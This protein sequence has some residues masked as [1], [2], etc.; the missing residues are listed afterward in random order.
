VWRTPALHRDGDAS[1]YDPWPIMLLQA[2]HSPESLL[3][4]S[5]DGREN[6]LVATSWVSASVEQQSVFV[7]FKKKKEEFELEQQ[8]AFTNYD[9]VR[10]QF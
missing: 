8:A 6:I 2:T 3:V 7:F 5:K 4:A 10:H 9:D 1:I